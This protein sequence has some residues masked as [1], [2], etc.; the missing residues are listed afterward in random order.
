MWLRLW[1]GASGRAATRRK[2]TAKSPLRSILKR[3]RHACTAGVVGTLGL[4]FAVP[5]FSQT[6]RL[7]SAAAAHGDSIAIEI[8]VNSSGGDEPQVL[9]WD[10]IIPAS[11]LSFLDDPLRPG[12]ASE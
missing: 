12:P 6:L 3:F 2:F 9:Q 11:Q 8:T 4:V 7:S 1:T 10:T 5:A